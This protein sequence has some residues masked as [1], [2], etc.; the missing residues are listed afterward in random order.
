M[1]QRIED[2]PEKAGKAF[3]GFTTRLLAAHPE[4]LT[5][6]AHAAEYCPTRVDVTPMDNSG[7]SREGVLCTYKKFDGYAPIFAYAGPHGFMLDN[8]LLVG[9]NPLQ[10][11]RHPKVAEASAA[12]G[13]RDLFSTSLNCNRCRP[14]RG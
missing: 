3:R 11:R 12:A 9:E 1:R 4:Y 2:L 10:H 13:W 6:Q 14:R 5:E 7:S 8:E